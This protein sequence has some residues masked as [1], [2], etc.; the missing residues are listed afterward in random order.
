VQGLRECRC[1]Q[2]RNKPFCD[3]LPWYAGFRDPLPA[4]FA[5]ADHFPW[6]DPNA[7]ERGRRRYA[8]GQAPREG[9]T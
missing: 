2:S 7:A 1:G 9:E 8:A 6:E 3:G 4:E 5:D